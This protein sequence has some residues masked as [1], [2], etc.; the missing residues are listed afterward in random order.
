MLTAPRL[1][2]PAL[3]GVTAFRPALPQRTVQRLVV[4]V[5][6]MQQKVSGWWADGDPMR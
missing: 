4:R 2:S 3:A 5:S 6:A 1:G